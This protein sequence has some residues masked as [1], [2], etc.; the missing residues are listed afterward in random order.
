MPELSRR[1][2]A[3][4]IHA[5]SR[6]TLLAATADCAIDSPQSVTLTGS[7]PDFSTSAS[8]TAITV[9]Q[10]ASGTS[11]I[12]LT[13]IAKFNQKVS[14]TCTGNPAN[15]TC[16]ISP[17]SVTLTGGSVSTT[18]LTIQTTSSTPVGTYTLVVTSTFQN[19]VHTSNITL[20]VM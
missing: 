4:E 12:S 3:M 9:T 8:P 5:T 14:L 19:L 16:T 7:G 18:T 1:S 10:G 13:P 20:T 6:P 2:W 15:S 11:T 17:N